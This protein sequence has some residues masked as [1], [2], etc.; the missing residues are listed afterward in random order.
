[1]A[2]VIVGAILMTRGA[3]LIPG[4]AQN[5]FEWFYEF[6]SDFGIGIAGPTGPPVHPDL[7]RRSSC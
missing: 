5:I 2:I 3:K 4:R 1:M 6:L 7:H